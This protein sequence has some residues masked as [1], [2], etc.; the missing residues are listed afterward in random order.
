MVIVKSVVITKD[1]KET[2]E[3]IKRTYG[4]RIISYTHQENYE[5]VYSLVNEINEVER[6][7]EMLQ[8]FPDKA[9]IFL[10]IGSEAAESESES[11]H[12][13]NREE[14]EERCRL[15]NKLQEL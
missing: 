9:L 4:K 8:E 3:K 13:S 15:L 10:K 11:Y 2:F 14:W 12:L 6:Y 1:D 5:L 7:F